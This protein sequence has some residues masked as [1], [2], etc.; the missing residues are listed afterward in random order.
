MDHILQKQDHLL[1]GALKGWRSHIIKHAHHILEAQDMEVDKSEAMH[2]RNSI[3]G[4][5]EGNF[6]EF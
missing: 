1:H 2:L 5:I 3:T 4:S 6:K